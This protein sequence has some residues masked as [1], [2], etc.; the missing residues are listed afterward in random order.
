MVARE[1]RPLVI[2][3]E[4]V[5]GQALAA[6]IMNAMRGTLKVAGIKAP[7]YGEE[8]RNTLDD[9]AISTGATFIT[10]QSGVK[11]KDI[12]MAHLGTAKFIESSKQQTTIVG[13]NCNF[14][15]VEQRIETLKQSRLQNMIRQL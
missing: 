7:M 9:L 14:E 2:I 4:E 11:L 1:S 10:R 15:A 6:M 13:G 3:G 8:R 12:K 5:E